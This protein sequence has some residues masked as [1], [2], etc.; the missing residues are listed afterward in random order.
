MTTAKIRR[1]QPDTTRA[2]LLKVARKLFAQRGYY[3]TGTEDIVGRANLT[4][5]ALY[6]HFADKEELFR[7][8][9]EETIEEAVGSLGAHPARLQGS[10]DQWDSD[11][12]GMEAYL[13]ACLEPS[14]SRI[15]L[16]D[17]PAVLGMHAA[18]EISERA[19]GSVWNEKLKTAMREGVI[20]TLPVPVLGH[21]LAA[22]VEEAGIYVIQADDPVAAR[23][24]VTKVLRRVYQGLRR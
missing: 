22:I 7:A 5:G 18:V 3:A 17:A 2:E 8:V 21:L 19:H 24:D 14:R 11:I 13:E 16:V 20:D 23:R 12:A 15:L 10:G 4:R 6:H 9:V 1:R